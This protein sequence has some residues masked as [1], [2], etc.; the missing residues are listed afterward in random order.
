[1]NKIII[2]LILL[3]FCDLFPILLWG[4]EKHQTY[5]KVS[6]ELPDGYELIRVAG[7]PL[8]NHPIMGCVDDYG[9]LFVGDAVGLNLD[10][11]DLEE[12]LPNRIL[13][14]EDLNNDGVYDKSTVFAD[15]MTFPQGA[16]WLNGSLYVASP[17]G[18]W[19]LTDTND[20]GVADLR[21]MIVGGF[22]FT[23]NAAG[24]HGPFLHPNGRL[25]W[26]HGRKGHKVVQKD[27]TLVHEG[28]ASGIWS[29]EPDGSDIEWYSL[30]AMDNPVEIDFTPDGDIIGVV[31]IML[32]NPRG[33]GLVHWLYGGVYPRSDYEAATDNLTR[34]IEKMP[35]SHNFGHQAVAGSSFYRSGAL[36]PEWKGN[37]FV[38][39]FN[40]QKML[41]MELSREGATFKSVENEFLKVNDQNAH[42][43]DVFEDLDGS[44]I[45]LDTG[46][47]FRLGCPTSLSEK[48][49]LK[50]A[51]YRIRK[52]D[53]GTSE[54]PRNW[55]D[56]W[57]SADAYK[58]ESASDET[59]ELWLEKGSPSQKLWA[60]EAIAKSRRLNDRQR[61]RI[62]QLLA[63]PMDSALEHA[64]MYAAI[65]TKAFL[66]KDIAESENPVQIRRLMVITEQSIDGDYEYD[67]LHSIAMKF[68]DSAD[69]E[70]TQ[71]AV[72]ILANHPRSIDISYNKFKL[73]L[74]EREL[75]F[76]RVAGIG[77][78]VEA[79]MDEE[80]S[81]NLISLM[82]EH[83]SASVRRSAW[84]ILANKPDAT[85]QSTWFPILEKSLALA[86]QVQNVVQMEVNIGD[87]NVNSDVPLI[88]NAISKFE[89]NYFDSLLQ[90][91][92][93]DTS[94]PASVR[95]KALNALSN[96]E[97]SL[98]REGFDLL[99]QTL[100]ESDSI[101]ARVEA[102]SLLASANLSTEQL[103]FLAPKLESVG[104]IELA[105]LFKLLQ[106]MNPETGR[107]W[108]ENLARSSVFR[109]G[110]IQ[111]SVVRSAFSKLPAD[112]YEEILSPV[113]RKAA[114]KIDAKRR[115]LNTFSL[116]VT[117]NGRPEKGR[118]VFDSGKGA[119]IACHQVGN[120]GL[121]IGP[122]L[123]HIGK[124]RKERDILESILFP[125]A[126]LSRDFEMHLIETSDGESHTGMIHSQSSEGIILVN[127]SGQK[128]HI[129]QDQIV[130]RSALTTSLMPMGLEQAMT[131][132]E[133]LDLVAWLFSLK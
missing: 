110:S 82:L 123:S 94:R 85:T 80:H 126:T 18:I 92:V 26:C 109:S 30:G 60:C 58:R 15:K 95:L 91:L 67:Q 84:N 55:A 20:D 36:N 98:R 45:V 3:F 63:E 61:K 27:G 8:V 114:Q 90:S 133:L 53:A 107:V 2:I 50:G 73:W 7:P 117:K 65:V 25:F 47:W 113:V 119:C 78:V 125:S 68:V 70:L 87:P 122:N 12:Q 102:A 121:G 129:P 41:R 104:P 74:N 131:D 77:A 75:S 128:T 5:L 81:Q 31:N 127:P 51:V 101:V 57:Y 132:Q 69:S 4:R 16:C 19:K 29:C 49:D 88:L 1:M 108:A 62:L 34:T 59:I 17:P 103:K 28:I 86:A 42:L 9:R 100:S 120:A 21:E 11:A 6:A 130:G 33:D 39:C 54:E 71:V 14:L 13:M 32:K 52:K 48:P 116:A 93:G 66:L 44:L 111:E 38:T 46:G 115:K 64:T 10:R 40:N 22:D 83:P 106:R 72:R 89:T 105:E 23:G 35:L 24:V 124:I 96:S 76:G 118:V 43:T 56:Q 37:M 97:G 99:E 112:I 79:H